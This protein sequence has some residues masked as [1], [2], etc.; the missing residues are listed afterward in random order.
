MALAFTI[1][2]GSLAGS[3]AETDAI[4][5]RMVAGGSF[6]VAIIAWALARRGVLMARAGSYTAAALLQ[7]AVT[8]GVAL[9]GIAA[10][11]PTLFAILLPAPFL[12]MLALCLPS[13]R[14]A[15]DQA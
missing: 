8:V 3:M 14:E 2:L 4:G 7:V 6:L 15:L 12:A 10:A 13:V 1:A 11:D 5:L 9:I